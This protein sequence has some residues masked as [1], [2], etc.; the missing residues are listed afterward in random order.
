[1]RVLVSGGRVFADSRYLFF[2]LDDINAVQD[3]DR[4]IQGGQRKWVPERERYVGAD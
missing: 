3:I 4:I 2:V 1:M